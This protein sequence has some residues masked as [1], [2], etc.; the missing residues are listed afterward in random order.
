MRPGSENDC[1][2]RN[3]S[4]AILVVDP[5]TAVSEAVALVMSRRARVLVAATGMGG[6]MIAADR[7]VTLVI[8][9]GCLPD[10]SPGEFLHILRLLRPGVPVAFL[11]VDAPSQGSL[12][13]RANAY[14]PEPIQLKGLLQWIAESLNLPLPPRS[15]PGPGV[16]APPVQY[17]GPV[18]HLEIVRWVVEFIERC[19][20]EGTRFSEVAQA[21]G[22]SRSHLCRI[23]KR[24]TGLPLKRFLT[25]RRLRV[26]K[27]LLREPGL[28]VQQVA[29]KV[30][31]PDPSHFNRVFRQWEGQPPS[32]YRRQVARQHGPRG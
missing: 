23:F 17:N 30:G 28:A 11:R 18:H 20:Q 8:V 19:Y 2:Y 27:E 26:A 31:Y 4:P 9:D 15:E 3:A 6:L 21:A 13:S 10:M 7:G 24:V 14:F 32:R 16:A 5:E 22:V 1:R 25:R 12:E 29:S